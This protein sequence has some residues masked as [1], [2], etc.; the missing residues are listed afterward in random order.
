MVGKYK[1]KINLTFIIIFAASWLLRGLLSNL[2]ADILFLDFIWATWFDLLWYFML[3]LVSLLFFEKVK[4]KDLIL[5]MFV[6]FIVDFGRVLILLRPFT[7]YIDFSNQAVTDAYVDLL[8]VTI[9]PLM[10]VVGG[11]AGK[12]LRAVMG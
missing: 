3:G 7:S 8:L 11:L 2:S 6:Y 10:I 1:L 9:S 5:V 12:K 4:I